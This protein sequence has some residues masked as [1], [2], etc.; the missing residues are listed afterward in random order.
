MIDRRTFI[1]TLAGGILASPFITFAQ[2]PAK[3]PRIGILGSEVGAHWEGF[4]QGMRDL[5]Y[6]A[7]A[8]AGFHSTA[9][10]ETFGAIP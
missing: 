8:L 3:L 5:G 2:Q 4:R 9:T 10:R 6:V 7:T 1:G